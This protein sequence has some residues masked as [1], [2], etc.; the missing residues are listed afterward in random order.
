[1]TEYYAWCGLGPVERFDGDD[2]PQASTVA[3]AID[4]FRQRYTKDD[5]DW[6]LWSRDGLKTT[7]LGIVHD[8]HSGG[9]RTFQFIDPVKS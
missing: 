4:I 6:T 9:N 1:M 3:E 7:L 8:A 5:K 2:F